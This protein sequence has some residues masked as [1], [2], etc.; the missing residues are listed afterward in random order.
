[1]RREVA[2]QLGISTRYEINFSNAIDNTTN[3]RPATHPYGVGNKVTSNA[4]TY[5]GFTNCFLEENNGIMRIY[6]TFGASNLAVV[7]NA[8]TLDYTTG[9][10]IL[11]NFAPTAF[12]DGSTTLKL[13]AFPGEKDILP[14]RNQIVQIRD[15]DITVTMLDD[16]TIS[17]V[18]R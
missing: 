3:G 2:I 17:L 9:K 14:L 6:R 13:T 16:K 18:N 11:T 1:M 12:A 15:A 4:F 5:L 8:G 7:S 10:I